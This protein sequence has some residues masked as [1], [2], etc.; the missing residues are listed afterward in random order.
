M[1]EL[2]KNLLLFF[3]AILFVACDIASDSDDLDI[4]EDSDETFRNSFRKW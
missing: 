4:D 2:R 3:A 1:I